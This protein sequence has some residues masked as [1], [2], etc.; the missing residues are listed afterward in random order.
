MRE[1]HLGE[2]EELVLLSILSENNQAHGVAIQ[3]KLKSDVNKRLSRGSLHTVLTRL[4]KKGYLVSE[5]GA[6]TPTRGGK[7]KKL[8]A[9]TSSGQNA[10]SAVK[11]MRDKY[12]QVIPMFKLIAH[13][14]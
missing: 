8:Y 3:E 14:A 1:V 10:L 7:S 4:E 9:V 5:R 2:L 11:E 6:P 12:Y 13:N